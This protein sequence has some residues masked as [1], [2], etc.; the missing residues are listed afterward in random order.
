[1]NEQQN[2]WAVDYAKDYIKKNSEFDHLLGIEAWRKMLGK[3]DGIESVLECGCNIGRNIKFLNEV[4]PSATKSVIEI[5][6]PAFEFVTQ[7]Y[8][9]D[10]AF[11]GSILEANFEKTF[12]LVFTMGVLI[13]IHPDQLLTN[14]RKIFVSSNKY[15]LMGEYFNRTPVMLTYQSQ[16]DKL[17]KRDFGKLF[18]EN[19][20]VTLVDFGFLWGHLY[21]SAG[22]DD[23]TW[24]L[25]EKK[26]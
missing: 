10:H 26:S 25:F 8:G 4:F 22:F 3:A 14:M 20:P 15:I 21:D 24:W 16:E 23:V 11:N 2:F 9:L 13:H 5:S 17:F 12:D 19:F 18:I 1:M 7:Q 6:K